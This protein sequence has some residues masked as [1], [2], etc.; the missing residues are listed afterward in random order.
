MNV[1]SQEALLLNGQRTVDLDA[2]KKQETSLKI[3]LSTYEVTEKGKNFENL[4]S[5]GNTKIWSMI[6]KVYD[7]NIT[8]TLRID[9]RQE[10]LFSSIKIFIS[11]I[12]LCI[13]F[14]NE[15]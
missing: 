14:N 1:A 10:T 5:S 6:S 4:N 2:L 15:D 11:S 3:I 13:D 12:I 7:L 9:S 8:F